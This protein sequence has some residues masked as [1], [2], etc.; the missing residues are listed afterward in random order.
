MANFQPGDKVVHISGYG[1]Y[2][3]VTESFKDREG[4]ELCNCEYWSPKEEKFIRERFPATSLK[5]K[6]S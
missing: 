3:A 4:V 2:M 1:P 5:I 6:N